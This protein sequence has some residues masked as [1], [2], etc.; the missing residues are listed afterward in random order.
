MNSPQNPWP[1][2]NPL[3]REEWDFR[4][5][6]D[7][8]DSKKFG[9]YEFL[10]EDE[11]DRCRLYE[12]ARHEPDA[13]FVLRQRQKLPVWQQWKQATLAPAMLSSQQLRDLS[14]KTFDALLKNHLS[15]SEDKKVLVDWYYLIWPEWPEMPFL[16][17]NRA[18]RARRYECCWGKRGRRLR[19]IKP[20]DF[21]QMLE[22]LERGVEISRWPG[23]FKGNVRIQIK[24]NVLVV[25]PENPSPEGA[26]IVVPIP[27]FDF[28][29]P[30]KRML[31][32]VN[33]WAVATRAKLFPTQKT[34]NFRVLTGAARKEL[35]QLGAGR[36]LATGKT[37]NQ[38]IEFTRK[39]TGKPLY[40]KEPDWC[41]PRKLAF[42]VIG[43][44]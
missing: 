35:N 21:R 15:T 31:A 37:A 7:E 38:A 9:P 19:V 4:S 18:E 14:K 42:K 17:I 12:F 5:M 40:A 20:S 36:L 8:Y 27:I 28:S 13:D 2:G 25:T 44:F 10:P 23:Y 43:Q 32:Q 34:K 3:Q 6:Y 33:N 39:L 22:D 24:D 16:S 29:L 1:T 30:E 11:V 26:Q 41:G